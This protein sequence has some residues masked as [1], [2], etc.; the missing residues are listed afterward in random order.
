MCRLIESIKVENRQLVAVQWHNKR[1][2]EARSEAFG[3]NSFVD[4]QKVISIPT[5]LTNKVYKCRVLYGKEIEAIDFQPYAIRPVKSLKLVDGGSIDYHLK[6][7][8]RNAL[9]DLLAQKGEADDILIVKNGCI[10]DTSYANIA[11]FDG[12]QWFTPDTYLLNGTKRQH[13]LFKGILQEK[14][15]KV[16][17]LQYYTSIKPINALLNFED[18]ESVVVIS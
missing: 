7:E 8:N 13:L 11:L 6:Y 3:V 15:I 16:N 2:N 12:K 5:T 4:L 17:D 14:Q 10:T 9:T 18:T 1:F